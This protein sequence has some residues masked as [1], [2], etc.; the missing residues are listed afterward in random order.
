MLHG[1]R[2][3][4]R[5]VGVR[6]ARRVVRRGRLAHRTTTA[7]VTASR[8]ANAKQLAA[9]SEPIV[10]TILEQVTSIPRMCQ[11]AGG[12]A[13]AVSVRDRGW[14]M[15]SRVRAPVLIVGRP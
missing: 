7:G 8:T 12:V 5:V 6:D 11:R 14:T 1:D 3:R 2:V 4:M 9:G 15:C 13:L 10:V